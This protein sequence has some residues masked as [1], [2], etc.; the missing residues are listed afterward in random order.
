M[1]P[2][3]HTRWIASNVATAVCPA[4]GAGGVP[5]D[6]TGCQVDASALNIHASSVYSD[7]AAGPTYPCS[8]MKRVGEMAV[9]LWKVRPRGQFERVG[10]WRHRSVWM[11]SAK[12]SR[13]NLRDVGAGVVV[14]PPCCPPNTQSVVSPRTHAGGRVRADGGRAR[15]G[16]RDYGRR[17]EDRRHR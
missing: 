9:A 4:R 15:V 13:Q 11:S 10:I 17:G 7:S 6:R 3:I 12:R 16:H 14:V 8:M 2:N 1:P 5:C